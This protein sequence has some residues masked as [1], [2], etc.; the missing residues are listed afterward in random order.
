MRHR[1][2]ILDDRE[3]LLLPDGRRA[4]SLRCRALLGELRQLGIP[5]VSGAMIK[6]E[7]LDRY[8]EV[9]S[10]ATRSL[11]RHHGGPMPLSQIVA[12]QVAAVVAK[13][14]ACGFAGEATSNPPPLPIASTNV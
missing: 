2:V 1:T 4:D 3:F 14:S 11:P 10:A 12:K 9:F 6:S 13:Q 8:E 5:G 7:L